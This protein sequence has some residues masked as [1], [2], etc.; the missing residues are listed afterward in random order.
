MPDIGQYSPEQPFV[1]HSFMQLNLS[2]A[3]IPRVTAPQTLSPEGVGAGNSTWKFFMQGAT[4]P[5]AGRGIVPSAPAAETDFYTNQKFISNSDEYQSGSTYKDIGFLI[6]RDN[7]DMWAKNR[8][9]WD[10]TF[11]T[12]I[13]LLDKSGAYAVQGIG[14]LGGLVGMGNKH[15]NYHSG[16]NFADW[17]AGASDNGLATWAK[18]VGEDVDNVYRPIYNEASDRDSG[19]F[20]R[21]FTDLDFWKGDVADGAAFLLSAYATGNIFNGLNLG[22]AAVRGI[23]SMRGLQFADEAAALSAEGLTGM[24]EAAMLSRGATATTQAAPII[25]GVLSREAG[26][27]VT[28]MTSTLANSPLAKG[29]NMGVNTLMLTASESL[30]E[31]SS[32]KK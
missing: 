5:F 25:P 7:E 27:I 12:V 8:T 18:D 6:G 24:S 1:P 32:L 31:A 15:N 3:F 2:N 28:D 19:F 29:I 4:N 14:F 10:E 11:N 26:A 30:T 16:S 17:I 22:G 23:N 9:W 21:M 20:S 13:R